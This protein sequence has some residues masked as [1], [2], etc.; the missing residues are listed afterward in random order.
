MD[1]EMRDALDA[2]WSAV[3]DAGP[4]ESYHRDVMRRHRREWPTLWRAIDAILI[5]DRGK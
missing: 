4:V 5:A 2:L 3:H 1:E